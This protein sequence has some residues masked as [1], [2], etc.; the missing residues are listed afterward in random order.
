M[1][2]PIY[3]IRCLMYAALIVL[4]GLCVIA[5]HAVPARAQTPAPAS[6]Q[7]H[8][9]A[10]GLSTESGPAN[11]LEGIGGG[12]TASGIARVQAIDPV[13]DFGSA[14]NGG[15]VKHVFKL[16]NVGTVPLIIGNV[17]TSCGCTAAAPSRSTVPPGEES[18]IAVTFDTRSDKGP[19]TRTITVMTNDSQHPQLLLTMKGDVKVLVEATPAPI[20]FGNVRHGTT[21]TRQ[22][23][24]TDLAGDK[25]LKV[26]PITNS[27][28]NLKVVQRPRIDGKPGAI[29]AITLLET[30][31]AG[32]FADIVKVTTSRA[33]VEIPVF[34]TVVGDLT[35]NPP[36][37]S[38]GIVPHHESAMR[39]IRLTNSGDRTVKVIGVS[40]TNLSVTAAVET[41][42]AGKQYK[43]TLQLAPNTPDGK[44]M[45]TVAINTDDP[46]QQTVQVPFYGIVGS[47]KG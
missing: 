27:S 26:G 25:V 2:R 28:T 31:P 4:I 43:I 16:K 29:L 47:F 9:P 30:A 41:V 18:D 45:G 40:S 42:K 21:Q 5:G 35:V 1:N 38:F 12:A 46:Q 23:T 32:P 36:Q 8:L 6:G 7:L 37:V 33:P 14:F 11:R 22:V 24:V 44:L 10:A 19:A 39:V 20:A 13:Y 34:G 17:Q 3:I 15:A